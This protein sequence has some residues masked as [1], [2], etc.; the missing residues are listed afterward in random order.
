PAAREQ[1]G[2]GKVADFIASLLDLP[3]EDKQKL[4]EL[5]DAKERL[6]LLTEILAREL[7]VLE[8]GQKIQE[9]VEEQLG[10]HQKEFVLRQQLAAI[11]KELGEV[12]ESQRDVDEL[13]QKLEKAGMPPEVRKEADRE[14]E[15]LSRIPAQAAEYSVARTYLEWLC[16]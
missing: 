4:L 1:A 14:L 11:K 13:A 9:T 16:D 5:I 2:P 8:V 7:Q 15:R 12:D 10:Q 3:A 6:Q